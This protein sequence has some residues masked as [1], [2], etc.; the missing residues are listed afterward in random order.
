MSITVVTGGGF[1]PIHVGHIQLLKAARAL[2]DKLIVILNSD[3]QLILKKGFVFMGEWERKTIMESIR[4][5]DQVVMDIDKDCTCVETLKLLKPD[6]LAKGG[7]RCCDE[8][9]PPEELKV[10]KELGIRIIYAVGGGKIQS[11]SWL[12]KK[13]PNK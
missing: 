12:T 10:C 8:D 3:R 5:V 1:D 13:V 9:M 4:Y 6:I 2:G 7:D 11:S